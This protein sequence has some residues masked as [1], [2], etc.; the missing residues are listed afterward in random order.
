MGPDL[1]SAAL[2]VAALASAAALGSAFTWW[3]FKSADLGRRFARFVRRLVRR[4]LFVGAL[5]ALAY[6]AL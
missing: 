6:L 1:L 5:F 2:L 4:T 3:T